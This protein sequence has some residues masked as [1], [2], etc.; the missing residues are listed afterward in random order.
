[1][2]DEMIVRRGVLL[3]H[4]MLEKHRAEMGGANSSESVKSSATADSQL[5]A[6]ERPRRP[7]RPNKGVYMVPSGHNDLRKVARNST[8]NERG[9]TIFNGHQVQH[10]SG[11]E[12]KVSLIVQADNTVADL[13]SQRCKI[14]YMEENGVWRSTIFDFLAIKTNGWRVGIA[15]KPERYRARMEHMFARIAETSN[16]TEIDEAVFFSEYQATRAKYA[17]ARQILWARAEADEDEVKFL[18]NAI[19]GRGAIQVWELYDK[20]AMGHWGRKAAIWRLIDLGLLVPEDEEERID[21]LTRL[22]INL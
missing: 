17:N 14:A 15:V 6:Y 4:R 9:F 3:R 20:S 18:A 1:M 8:K 19:A 5:P 13:F 2:R 11:L 21:D 12:R 22:K 10:E 7:R 16:Q